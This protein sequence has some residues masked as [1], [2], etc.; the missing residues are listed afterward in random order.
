MPQ[1]SPIDITNEFTDLNFRGIIYSKINKSEPEQIYNTDVEELTELILDEDDFIR[2]FNGLQ[3][4]VALKKLTVGSYY[5]VELDVSK[6]TMLEKLYITIET[7]KEIDLSKNINLRELEIL[8]EQLIALD[9]SHNTKLEKLNLWLSDS[10]VT[11]LDLSKNTEL[12]EL[13][14]MCDKVTELD[15]SKNINLKMFEFMGEQLTLDNVIGI[16]KLNLNEFVFNNTDTMNIKFDYDLKGNGWAQINFELND[17]KLRY[18][19]SYIGDNPLTEIFRIAVE[20]LNGPIEKLSQIKFGFLFE[21]YGIFDETETDDP[22][23]LEKVKNLKI[24]PNKFDNYKFKFDQEGNIVEIHFKV[25][26]VQNKIAEIKIIEK[27]YDYE[28]DAKAKIAFCGT[29]DFHVFIKQMLN[30]ATKI[31]KEYGFIEYLDNNRWEPFPI[32]DYLKVLKFFEG[33]N[34]QMDIYEEINLLMKTLSSQG[35]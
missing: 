22:V 24:S 29:I 3:Y 34:K 6:N 35:A 25:Q 16:D 4:L 23:I 17:L 9:I 20:I 28:E 21:N 8:S 12:E 14:I 15:L 13:I 32:E 30:S 18:R 33:N 5:T 26:S 11:I 27:D 1:N 10:L 19:A 2:N 7:L 31:L